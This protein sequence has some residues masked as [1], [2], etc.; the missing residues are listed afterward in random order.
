MKKSLKC[1]LLSGGQITYKFEDIS[2]P[3]AGVWELSVGYDT[4]ASFKGW[5]L[6]RMKTKGKLRYR[7]FKRVGWLRYFG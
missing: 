6:L 4:N 3:Y 1:S 7:A 2:L 5:L